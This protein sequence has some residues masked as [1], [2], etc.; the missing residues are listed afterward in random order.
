MFNI[1]W[2]EELAVWILTTGV[3]IR[4]LRKCSFKTT[5]NISFIIYVG[6]G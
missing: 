4:L 2:Q 1:T 6:I 5:V 3:K